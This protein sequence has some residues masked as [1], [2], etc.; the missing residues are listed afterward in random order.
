[1]KPAGFY[2]HSGVKGQGHDGQ[3]LGCAGINVH[4]WRVRLAKHGTPTPSLPLVV[5]CIWFSEVIQVT[6]LCIV[7][8]PLCSVNSDSA[9]TEMSKSF[10]K[11]HTFEVIL[12]KKCQS[13][14]SNIHISY[15]F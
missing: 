9:S 10:C 1:M 4:S 8:S 11:C 5:T 14:Q 7:W 13:G 15:T 6:G 12:K 3:M 2:G